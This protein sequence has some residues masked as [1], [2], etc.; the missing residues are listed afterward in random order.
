MIL[1]CH[2]AGCKGFSDGVRQVK[3]LAAGDET[4]K[5]TSPYRP[6]LFWPSVPMSGHVPALDAGHGRAQRPKLRRYLRASNSPV[7][8]KTS[9][10]FSEHGCCVVGV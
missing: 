3:P 9:V 4:P 7:S 10:H 1:R 8:R 5:R 2:R 6:R